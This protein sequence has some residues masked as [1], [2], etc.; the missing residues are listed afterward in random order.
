MIVSLSVAVQTPVA[1]VKLAGATQEV[2]LL[3][4]P[5]GGATLAL[6]VAVWAKP[7]L[8]RPSA[9]VTPTPIFST[10]D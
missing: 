7:M 5:P 10:S 9:S 3:V 4:M 6:L 2:P 1:A 8:A